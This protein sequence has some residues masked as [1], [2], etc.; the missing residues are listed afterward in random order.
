MQII[1]YVSWK[2]LPSLPPKSASISSFS[3]FHLDIVINSAINRMKHSIVTFLIYQKLHQSNPKANSK[4]SIYVI[5][6]T[7]S[8]KKLL[9]ILVT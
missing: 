8:K 3:P 1:H 4:N 7:E 9:D 5:A 2:Q 6:I